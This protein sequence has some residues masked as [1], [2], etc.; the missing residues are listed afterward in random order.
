MVTE[1]KWI[2]SARR[3]LKNHSYEFVDVKTGETAKKK[4]PDS[5]MLDALTANMLVT[6][7]DG[8]NEINREIFAGLSLS[9]AV[10]VGW[11]CVKIK[12]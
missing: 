10:S 5:V 2:E 4:D 11:K 8:L 6:V 9:R 1:P 12:G 3:I 7:Y